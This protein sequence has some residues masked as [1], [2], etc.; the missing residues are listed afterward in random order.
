MSPRNTKNLFSPHLKVKSNSKNE[1]TNRLMIKRTNNSFSIA[2]ILKR[3]TAKA[4]IPKK[5]I[6][7]AYFFG[8]VNFVRSK[9]NK[10]PTTK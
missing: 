9:E 5:Q 7:K 4:E 2:T 1:T 10:I 6:E 3:C 8:I